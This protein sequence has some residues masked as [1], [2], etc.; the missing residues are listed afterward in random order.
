MKNRFLKNIFYSLLFAGLLTS[1]ANDDFGVPN[2]E[3]ID[4]TNGATASITGTEVYAMANS[5][6]K[7]FPEEGPELFLEA[8]VTS[9]DRGGNFFKVVSMETADGKGMSVSVDLYNTYNK[10]YQVGRKVLIKLNGLYYI[11]S[12]NS[13][14]I[15]ELYVN[16]GSG[17]QNTG[18]IAERNLPNHIFFTCDYKAEQDLIHEVT[19]AQAKNNNY[20]NMLL[21]LKDVQFEEVNLPYF[22]PN[23]VIGGSTNRHI[24]DAANN[25]VIFR[26]G[27]FADYAGNIIPNKSGSVTGVMTKFNTDF[28]FVARDRHDIVLDQLPLSEQPEPEPEIPADPTN[29]FFGGS[30]FEDWNVFNAS[31]NSFGLKYTTQGIG[32]GVNNSNSMRISGS[33]VGNDYIFTILSSAKGNIPANPTKITLWVKGTSAKSLSFNVYRPTTGYEV[34]N[35]DDLTTSPKVLSKASINNTTGNGSNSYIGVINTNNQWVKITLDISDVQLNLGSGDLFAV[36]VGKEAFYDL[37]IDN[38]EIE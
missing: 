4:T 23:N 27:S 25:S 17:A 16:P 5:T 21:K 14:S 9:S 11:I 10:G 24:V 28:Q 18:R 7:Q 20:I 19:V 22:D 12:N 35:I 34:F 33:P 30:D 1:C 36:K 8:Y 37:H 26:T 38:I 3:C 2:I 13:L 31:V 32:T 15:G 6:L 29:L